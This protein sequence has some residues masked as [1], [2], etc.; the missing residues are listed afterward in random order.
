CVEQQNTIVS[1]QVTA[2]GEKDDLIPLPGV[3]VAVKGTAQGTVT[4]IEGKYQLDAL[5]SQAVLV[6]SFV[7]YVSEEVAVNEK[8]QINITLQTDAK[9]LGEVVVV[10]AVMKKSDLTGAVAS[11]EGEKLREL[12]T[13]SVTQAL[14]GRLAGVL[15]QNHSG[16]SGG[17][18]I[19]IR[20]N[21]SIQFGNNP[22]FVVDGLILDGGFNLLNP[23]DIESIDVLKDASATSIYGARGANGVVLVTTKKGKKGEGKIGYDSWYGVQQFTRT[24]PRLGAKDMFDLRVEANA[25]TY[26]DENP[27]ANREQYINNILRNPDSP[28]TPF[29][30]YEFETYN[31]GKSY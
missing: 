9:T 24:M 22:I 14:T 8:S 17:A 29:A 27:N 21:N 18:S 20:G 31:S 5:P 3:H 25:N 23:S 12:P 28:N 19:K 6:F 2:Q 16:V 13:A 11:I 4:D 7:G 30:P 10:G 26:M 15:I 1:G